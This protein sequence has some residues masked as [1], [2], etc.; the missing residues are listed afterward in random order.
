MRYA[1]DVPGGKPIAVLSQSTS[2]VS[3]DNP[4]VAFYHIHGRKDEVL[5]FF[6][7]PDTTRIKYGRVK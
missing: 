1:A 6:S 2:G 5:F 4:L 3:A 7:V